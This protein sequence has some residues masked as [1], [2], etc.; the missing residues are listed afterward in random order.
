MNELT[1]KGCMSTITQLFDGDIRW[2]RRGFDPRVH[3][4]DQNTLALQIAH[5]D[6]KPSLHVHGTVPFQIL[7]RLKCDSGA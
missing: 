1:I 2:P 5:L 6:L 3:S 4:P 7:I